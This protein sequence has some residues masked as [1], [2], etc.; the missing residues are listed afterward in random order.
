MNGW[1]LLVTIVNNNWMTCLTSIKGKISGVARFFIGGA[2]NESKPT[3][4][5]LLATNK[6]KKVDPFF[7]ADTQDFESGGGD[8]DFICSSMSLV[9]F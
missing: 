2:R 4:L 9:G 6:I 7:F 5:L 8:E 3:R 1:S